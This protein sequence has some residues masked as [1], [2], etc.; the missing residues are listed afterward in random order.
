MAD[1]GTIMHK[2]VVKDI[3]DHVIKVEIMAQSACVS[4]KAQAICGVD[5]Q[6]KIIE[7]RTW[8]NV[9]HVGEPVQVLLRESL[10][11]KALFLAYLIPFLI[12]VVVLLVLLQI[13]GKEGLS[14]L[15]AIGI[16]FP[17]FGVL[18]FYRAQLQKTFSF[19]IAKNDNY[20]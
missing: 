2:G 1:V 7:I 4:C 14:A 13:T 10:G 18:Y 9:F 15:V 8:N 5:T 12:L 3:T 16:L 6:E 11:M 17:Y 20:I 19:D